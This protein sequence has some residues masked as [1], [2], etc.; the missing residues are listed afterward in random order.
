MIPTRREFLARNP[1]PHRHTLGLFY[2]EKLAAIWPLLAGLAPRRVLEVGGG[3]S[4]LT[5][6]CFP[7]ADIVSVDRDRSE[8]RAAPAGSRRVQ[9][10]AVRLP[11]A[12]GAFDCVTMFDV[13]EHIPDDRAAAA[14]VDRVLAPGG[15]LLVSTPTPAFRYPRLRLLRPVL[16]SEAEILA[17]WGHVRIGYRVEQLAALWPGLRLEEAR[18]FQNGLTAIAHDVTFAHWSE[19]TRRLVTG[20]LLPV[21]WLGILLQRPSRGVMVAVRFRK[22]NAP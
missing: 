18:H 20:L 14:E 8:L 11:F 6:L 21:T 13:L 10:D 2:R 12:D 7:A 16:P 4:G 17:A 22:A 5:Q 19:R 15:V 3:R 9:V 1:F